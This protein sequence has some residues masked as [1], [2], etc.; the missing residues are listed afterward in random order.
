MISKEKEDKRIEWE[1]KLRRA[2]G[3][4]ITN[5]KGLDVSQMEDLRSRCDRESIEY[6]VI[7]NRIVKFAAIGAGVKKLANYLKGPVGLA[8]S[9]SDPA[10]PAKVL[11]KFAKDNAN[12]KI[13][14]AL[15][16]ERDL[17]PDYIDELAALPSKDLLVAKFIADLKSPISNFTMCL[18]GILKKFVYLLNQ[19][20]EKKGGKDASKSK[21][22]C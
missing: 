1:N 19:I 13:L 5:F 18:S 20:E 17:T 7:K 3:I 4:Y 14:G 6:K 2:Q 10:A 11:K 22:E 21:E 9:Y 15:V 8:L 16:E 12:F